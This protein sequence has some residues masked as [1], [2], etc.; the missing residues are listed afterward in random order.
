[1]LGLSGGI[2]SALA[3]AIAARAV[4]PKNVH[5]LLMP[6]RYSSQHS[7]DDAQAL[8]ENLGIDSHIIPIEDVHRAYEVLPVI[9]DDLRGQPGSLADQNL[10]ARIRGAIV[11]TRSN[12]HGWIALATGNKSELAVG[13]CTLYGDMCGGFAVLSDVLKRD[14]YAVS[15]YINEIE[16]RDIIPERTLSKAPSAELA[17]NQFDQDTLPPYPLLDAILEGLVEHEE[18]VRTLSQTYPADVVKWVARALDRNEFKRRQMPPGIKLSQRAF[19]T[20]RR[21]PMAA[22]ID[23]E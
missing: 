8:A 10:Q 13:Y 15:R 19:G 1:V 4:G 5:G 23:A 11:M 9:G 21:M 16:G 22:R 6:S 7:V 12:R 20:G 18:S 17:P 14:V 3:A 2:D